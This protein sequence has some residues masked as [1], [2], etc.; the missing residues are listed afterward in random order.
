MDECTLR[1]NNKIRNN[2]VFLYKI[3]LTASQGMIIGY[4]EKD[5]AGEVRLKDSSGSAKQA[6]LSKWSWTC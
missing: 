2:K 3:K 1:N 5:L 6:G 4:V